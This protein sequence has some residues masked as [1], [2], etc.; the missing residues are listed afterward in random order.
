MPI[1]F[2]RY[3]LGEPLG[4]GGTAT[5]YR[6]RVRGVSGAAL[7]ARWTVAL[8]EA[9]ALAQG[10]RVPSRRAA[11]HLD[12]GQVRVVVSLD[13]R[14]GVQVEEQLGAQLDSVLVDPVPAPEGGPPAPFVAAVEAALRA[15]QDEA[16][17]RLARMVASAKVRVGMEKAAALK[18]MERFL[19]QSGVK[20]AERSSVLAEAAETYEQTIAALGDA[21]LELDQAALVQLV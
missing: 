11:R 16:E 5:V 2:G 6:A 3:E 12:E 8:P 4:S 15:G 7:D 17:K 14:G 21:R 9:A 10:A 20:E 18:R 13:G 19:A 1:L